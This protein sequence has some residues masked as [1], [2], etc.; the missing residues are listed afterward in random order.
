M[1]SVA[2]VTTP[3]TPIIDKINAQRS[4]MNTSSRMNNSSNTSSKGASAEGK[5]STTVVDLNSSDNAKEKKQKRLLN[6]PEKTHFNNSENGKSASAEGYLKTVVDSFSSDDANGK[7]QGGAL[8]FPVK[9]HC[10]LSN[11]ECNGEYAQQ[12]NI[13]IMRALHSLI[14]PTTS[15]VVCNYRRYHLAP[16]WYNVSHHR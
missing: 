8:K 16:I 10:V 14:D 11:K 12:S 6:F 13:N 1:V 3:P 2:P 4:N 7:K 5:Y 15:A 9:L